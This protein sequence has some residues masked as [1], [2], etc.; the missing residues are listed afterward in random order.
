MTLVGNRPE[1]VLDDGRVLPDRR[2]RAAVHRAAARARTCASDWTR[3]RPRRSWR[4]S[5]TWRS[6]RPRAPTARS[7]RSPT[8]RCSRPPPRAGRRPAARG[9]VPDHVHE[10]HGR[11]A[12]GRGAR[13]ALPRPASACRPSTGSTPAPASS[14]GARRPAAGRKSARNA[15]IAPWLRG[16]AALLHDERFDPHERLELLARERV[17]C[18]AWRRP[19]TASSPSAPSRARAR[20]CAAWSPPARRSNP[21]VL[22]AWQE[23]TGPLVRDG[24]GQTETGQLTGMPPG[25][26]ARP[27]SM[28]RPL[29]GVA[30]RVDGRRARARRPGDRSRPSSSATSASPPRR[31]AGAP[32]DRVS[33]DEDGYLFFEGRSDDV[34]I[35][36]GYR[37]GPF[38]VESALVAHPAVAEAA[39]VAAPDDERGAS[40]G[41]SS[42]C[43]TTSRPA[44]RSRA[45]CRT[46][47]RPRPRPTSTRGSSS[48]P[49]ELPRTPSGKVKRAA[50]RGV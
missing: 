1:W 27:G 20:R 18:C 25:D 7:S 23:A 17:T 47:S 22:R 2:G 13:P 14:S 35:S 12:Q 46:T 43:A 45:S 19:S 26:P 32:G 31:G 4:T 39:V 16:A 44:T 21:E 24:Y 36:A 29:P 34:I 28:G 41:P 30:L 11:R 37:I 49:A 15:F 5:A 6:S 38:E 50:L 33:Q 3:P 9:P 8:S 42:S 40:C 10:R 48:S